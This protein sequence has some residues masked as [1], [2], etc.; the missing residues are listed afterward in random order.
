MQIHDRSSA[1]KLRA[2]RPECT[3][4]IALSLEDDAQKLIAIGILTLLERG[5]RVHDV[6]GLT[7]E[8]VKQV[9]YGY[10]AEQTEAIHNASRT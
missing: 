5:A 10:Q 8:I 4:K 7:Q 1:D 6:A 9:W 3:K 2:I